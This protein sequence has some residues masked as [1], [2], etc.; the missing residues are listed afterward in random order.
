MQYMKRQSGMTMW[1]MLFVLGT[2][3]FALFLFFKLLPPYLTDFKI[4]SALSSLGQQSDAGTMSVAE[5]QDALYKRLEI[6][7][8][9]DFDLKDALTVENRGNARIIRIAYQATVPM[10][11]NISALID[12][13][14]R[15]EV[16]GG[17]S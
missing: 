13:D 8:A 11:F 5:I 3:A 2:F 10:A 12:F 14:H 16:R 4:R 6:D 17:S 1:G 9:D 7:S 15:I